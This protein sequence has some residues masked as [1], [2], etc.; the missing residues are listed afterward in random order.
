MRRIDTLE[1]ISVLRELAESGHEVCVKVSG[2]SM[3][4]F[5]HSGRDTVF[6]KSPTV[7]CVSATSC[8]I[9]AS[10]GSTFSTASAKSTTAACTCSATASSASR[11]QS[12]PCMP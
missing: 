1:Y 5:L 9:S 4:P 12:H 8:F 3:Y 11:G 10:T 2:H 6:L 7:S